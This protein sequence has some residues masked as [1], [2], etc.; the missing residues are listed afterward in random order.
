MEPEEE[1]DQ[2][3]LCTNSVF[4]RG[5]ISKTINKLIFSGFWLISTHSS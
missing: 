1:L 5:K 4:I 3:K 2:N